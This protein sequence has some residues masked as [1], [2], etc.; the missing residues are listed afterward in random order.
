MWDA[1]ISNRILRSK[2]N[3]IIAVEA[4]KKMQYLFVPEFVNIMNDVVDV[5]KRFI[6]SMEWLIKHFD[7]WIESPI[8]QPLSY[9]PIMSQT[10]A[11]ALT[12]HDESNVIPMRMQGQL[13]SKILKHMFS[14]SSLELVSPFPKNKYKQISSINTL[15]RPRRVGF[16]SRSFASHSVGKISVGLLEKLKEKYGR[17]MDIYVYTGFYNPDDIIAKQIYNSAKKFCTPSPNTLNQ[18][19]ECILNDSLDSIIY[20][21]PIMDINIYLLACFRLAPVQISTWGHPDTTGLPFIDFYIS[22]QL[23]EVPNAQHHYSEKLVCMKSMS[24]YYK[25]V[26]RLFNSNIVQTL[27][28]MDPLILKAQFGLP[29]FSRVYGITGTAFKIYPIM[30]EIIY[31]LLCNDRDAVIVLI[32]GHKKKLFNCVKERIIKSLKEDEQ[33]RLIV[34]PQQNSLSNYLALVRSFDVVLDTIPFGGCI[35]I[36]E[37][38][39]MGRCIVT[40]PTSKLYGRFTKGLLERL[41]VSELVT[42]SIDDYVRVAQKLTNDASLR[43]S[44]ESCILKNLN[45][46]L[47]DEIAVD[48]WFSFLTGLPARNT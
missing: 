29:D 42:S 12:Y 15:K 26:D 41:G 6:Q 38:L 10:P 25:H 4:L 46:V 40:L 16:V 47:Q 7:E 21:D 28:C 39:F 9:L 33:R 31:K 20:L 24:F 30:D 23:F 17:D 14:L 18:W 27:L 13:Y 8:V 19:I 34:V 48:E 45:N 1:W 3:D 44:I 5:R 2:C 22:S 11:Y 32:E 37:T 36:F 43:K 35:S